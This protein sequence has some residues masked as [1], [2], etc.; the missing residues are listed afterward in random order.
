[1]IKWSYHSL[2]PE[3]IKLYWLGWLSGR[4]HTTQPEKR[5]VE[6]VKEALWAGSMHHALNSTQLPP[7]ESSPFGLLPP[8][9]DLQIRWKSGCV[10][11]PMPTY[12]TKKILIGRSIWHLH[13]RNTE[14]FQT[15]MQTELDGR[16]D[17]LFPWLFSC[18]G[19]V[20][21]KVE[22]SSVELTE[23]DKQLNEARV[24]VGPLCVM[25]NTYQSLQKKH[26]C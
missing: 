24:P 13:T 16:K 2:Y 18:T 21:L 10:S 14:V 8:V 22:E 7:S 15:I 20:Y 26:E 5:Q 3:L 19:Q 1:M 11:F 9:Q 23:R 12:I 25:F 6:P 4:V 17:W